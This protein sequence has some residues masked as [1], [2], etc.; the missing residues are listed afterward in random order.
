[1][2]GRASPRQPHGSDTPGPGAHEVKS[3]LTD[4]PKYSVS[5]PQ[6]PRFYQKSFVPGPGQY[7]Q[8]SKAAISPGGH[9]GKGKRSTSFEA[10]QRRPFPH[11]TPGPGAHDV[12]GHISKNGSY[13]PRGHQFTPN[14][15]DQGAPDRSPG[16][17]AYGCHYT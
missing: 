17:G 7:S 14:R 12:K 13:T 8:D 4:G 2:R 16:P 10:L 9:I 5:V 6:S 3:A 1:M 11:D 15:R